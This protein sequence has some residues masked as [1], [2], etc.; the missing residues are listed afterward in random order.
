MLFDYVSSSPYELSVS[1]GAEVY[2]LEEDDGSGWIKVVDSE[3]AKGLVPASYL[4][5]GERGVVISQGAT[6]YV[7]GIYDYTAQGEDEISIRTGQMIKL[8]EGPNGGQHYADGWW[9]GY[10]NSNRRGIF[11]SNYVELAQ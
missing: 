6:Q 1:E 10:D 8:T 2:I 3:G 4:E 9:E 7:R 5:V 11:P